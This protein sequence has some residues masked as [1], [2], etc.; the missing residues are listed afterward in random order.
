MSNHAYKDNLERWCNSLHEEFKETIEN[1]LWSFLNSEL[2]KIHAKHFYRHRLRFIDG[3]GATILRVGNRDVDILSDIEREDLRLM[4]CFHDL[5]N[6]LQWYS[7]LSS[8]FNISIKNI[9]IKPL[10]KD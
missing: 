3:M 4:R 6:L 9:N 5:N 2:H 10:I 1:K 7:D 8:N